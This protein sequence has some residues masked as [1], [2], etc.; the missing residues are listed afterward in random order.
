M[1]A[2]WA[3]ETII[4]EIEYSDE[5][6]EQATITIEKTIAE[7]LPLGQYEIKAASLVTILANLVAGN[8]SCSA[9]LESGVYHEDIE[10]SVFIEYKSLIASFCNI[11]GSPF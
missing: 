11:Q 7:L 3:D 5:T 9:V 1:V 10:H 4:L 6:G 8:L 2:L